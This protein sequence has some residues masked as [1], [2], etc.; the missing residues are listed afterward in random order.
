MMRYLRDT[1]ANRFERIQHDTRRV[2]LDP[3]G[4][5]ALLRHGPRIADHNHRQALLHR[6]ADAAGTRFADKEVAQL[7]VVADL[8]SETH[9]KAWSRGTHI[10]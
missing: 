9:H 6:L 7:H 4:V 8:R 5:V 3:F 2:L 1:S 10:A